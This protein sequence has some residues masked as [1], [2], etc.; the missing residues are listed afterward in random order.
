MTRTKWEKKRVFAADQLLQHADVSLLNEHDFQEV[1]AQTSSNSIFKTK[2]HFV[3]FCRLHSYLYTVE[4]GT[5]RI[6]KKAKN[7]RKM[8]Q[9]AMRMVA[10]GS[11]KQHRLTIDQFYSQLRNNRK[12]RFLLKDNSAGA[13]YMFF[14]EHQRIFRLARPFTKTVDNFWQSALVSL[15]G[16]FLENST[17]AIFLPHLAEFDDDYLDVA[18]P[19]PSEAIISDSPS[20]ST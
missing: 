19:D 18:L 15:K 8:I 17:P 1:L 9:L 12:T 7:V 14:G 6:S 20:T 10:R 13:R 4:R 16:T 3:D 2:Q 5:G 11:S